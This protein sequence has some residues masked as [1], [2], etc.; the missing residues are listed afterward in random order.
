MA[1]SKSTPR[2]MQGQAMTE[3]NIAAAA[4][5]VP[6]FLFIP[7]V[8]KFIDIQQAAIQVA[9]YEAWE[10]TAWL[11]S[12]AERKEGFK[13]FPQ[14]VKPAAQTRNE[15]RNRLLGNTAKP[16]SGKD[17]QG[18]NAL[19]S[20][21]NPAWY[22]HR[23]ERLIASKLPTGVSP[24]QFV[25]TPNENTPD[26]TGIVP[27][28][29]KLAGFVNDVLGAFKTLVGAP[30][31]FEAVDGKGYRKTRVAVPVANIE[32]LA[33]F[34]PAQ[35]D[36]FHGDLVFKARAA[37]LAEGWS[38]GGTDHAVEQTQGLIVTSLLDNK[39]INV[40]QTILGFV[41]PSL[42]PSC[43]AFG[44]TNP[45]AVHPDRLGDQSGGHSCEQ[46]GKKGF[47]DFEPRPGI[48]DPAHSCVF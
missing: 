45:D 27:V 38:S 43:L 47:C 13:V 44:F 29:A 21:I 22:D 5:L 39:P 18:W 3:L 16:L 40:M 48:R 9:R 17:G 8:G 14:G 35:S 33:P 32:G 7:L 46:N 24:S 23:H 41:F 37:V 42:K 1:Q 15:A 25:L 10:Y 34:D 19:T 4:V 26:L 31:N 6:L 36:H 12:S 2:D 28:V 20:D 30:G 11:S